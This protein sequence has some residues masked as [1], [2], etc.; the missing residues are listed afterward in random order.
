MILPKY[1]YWMDSI[2]YN[3]KCSLKISPKKN[4]IV[5]TFDTNHDLINGN[6]LPTREYSG[7]L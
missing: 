6:P 7:I 1:I 2:E 3:T 5:S 4:S